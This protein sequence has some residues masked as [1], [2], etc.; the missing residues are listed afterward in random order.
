[1]GVSRVMGVA[2]YHWWAYKGISE[3]NM[4]D[5]GVSSGKLT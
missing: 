1:M 3:N 2:L 4:D 5:L